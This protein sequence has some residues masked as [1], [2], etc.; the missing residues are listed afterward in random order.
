M[1]KFVYSNYDGTNRV[2]NENLSLDFFSRGLRQ[3]EK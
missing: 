1:V 2:P 3:A